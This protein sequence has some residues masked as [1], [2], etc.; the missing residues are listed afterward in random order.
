MVFNKNVKLSTYYVVGSLAS[1]LFIAAFLTISFAFAQMYYLQN[2][3]SYTKESKYT[4]ILVSTLTLVVI[5][6]LIV[7]ISVSYTK[8]PGTKIQI[9]IS[10]SYLICVLALFGWA[11]K[12]KQAVTT[13]SELAYNHNIKKIFIV[14]SLC[15][16][17]YI[18][19][20]IIIILDITKD[21]SD[22]PKAGGVILFF[23]YF[24]SEI[25]P[26][27]LI[28]FYIYRTPIKKKKWDSF[29]KGNGVDE[30]IL[31]DEDKEDYDQLHEDSND[32]L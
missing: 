31:D 7:S 32:L 27:L 16:L 13:S 14:V 26:S 17:L 28:L 29:K 20:I 24:L 1:V 23:L 18:L 30:I 21:I 22:D 11:L 3:I 12:F 19:R 4:R 5:I 15:L 2:N 8:D 9:F 6:M 10:V 25:V